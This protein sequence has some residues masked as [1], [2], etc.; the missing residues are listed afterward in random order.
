MPTIADAIDRIEQ[1]LTDAG[2]NEGDHPRAS[3]G[4]F[5]SGGGGSGS[6]ASKPKSSGGFFGGGSQSKM[7]AALHEE[8]RREKDV[9]KAEKVL[10]E[11]EAEMKAAPEDKRKQHEPYVARAKSAL[12]ESR[13]LHQEATANFDRLAEESEAK[14]RK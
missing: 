13:R 6:G 11:A 8:G 14:E 4:Q 5:G 2:F 7:K 1:T 9:T 10:A 3:N 12:A